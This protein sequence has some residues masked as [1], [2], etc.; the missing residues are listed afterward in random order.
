MAGGLKIVRLALA[1]T[2]LGAKM[3]ALGSTVVGIQI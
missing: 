1:C 2:N 3:F